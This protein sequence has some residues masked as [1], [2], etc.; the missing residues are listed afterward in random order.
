MSSTDKTVRETSEDAAP[1]E[2]SLSPGPSLNSSFDFTL[3]AP[4]TSDESLSLAPADAARLP[5]VEEGSY[6]LKAEIAQGGI[7]RILR[8][9]DQRLERPVAIKELIERTP[10][11]ERRFVREAL[12]TARLQHPNIVPV[13]EAGRWPSGEPFYAM[14]FVCG[15]ALSKVIVEAHTLDQRLA[16]LPHVIAVAE[17]MAYAHS[18]G[19]IH[20][21]LKP[22]NVLVGPFGETVVID[23]G[24]AKNL[25]DRSQTP[26]ISFN[27]SPRPEAQQVNSS[28]SGSSAL[29]L[30]GA[31]MGTPAYMPPEQA[32]GRLVDE[33]ADVYALGAML[34]HLLAGSMPYHKS[35][36]G[37][38]LKE[39]RL[40][41]PEPLDR[42]QS[43]VPKD[44]L[45]IVQKAMER[46]PDKRYK[47]AAELALDLR[48]FQTGQ[49]VQAH[50]Y[51]RRERVLRFIKRRRLPLLIL[52]AALFLVAVVATVSIMGVINARDQARHE[53]DR[54]SIAE[55]KSTDRADGLTLV[56]AKAV[57]SREPLESLAWLKT[58]SPGFDRTKTVRLI[59]A[60]AFSRGVPRLLRGPGAAVN[61]IA[62]SPDGEWLA[63]ASDD[64]RVYLWETG[65]D[66]HKVLEGHSDEVW[67]LGFHKSGGILITTSK[68][69][70]VRVWDVQQ[71]QSRALLGHEGPINGLDFLRDGRLLTAGRDGQIH[72]WNASG[73]EGKLLYNSPREELRSSVCSNAKRAVFS[74]K[75]ALFIFDA[76]NDTLQEWPG[77]ELPA[78]AIA[79]SPDGTSAVTGDDKGGLRAWDLATGKTEYFQ[80]HEASVRTLMFAHRGGRFFSGGFDRTVRVWSL[81]QNTPETIFKGHEGA[82]YRIALSPDGNSLVSASADHSARIWDLESGTARILIGAH[83]GISSAEYSK[84]GKWLAVASYDQSIRLYRVDALRDRVVG[85][86]RMAAHKMALSPDGK[87][88]ITASKDGTLLITDVETGQSRPF[89]S[90][91]GALRSLAYSS[92][93]DYVAGACE[94]GRVRLWKKSGEE[95]RIF[96]GHTRA[97]QAMDFSPGIQQ[98]KSLNTLASAGADGSVKLWTL[99]TGAVQTLYQ[100]EQGIA[101]LAFS[102]DGGKL[103]LGVEDGSVLLFSGI[104]TEIEAKERKPIRLLGHKGSVL[105]LRF[106]PDGRMLATGSLDHTIRLWSGASGACL[107]TLDAGGSG[108]EHLIFFNDGKRLASLGG[109]ANARLWNTE[110]GERMDVLRGHRARVTTMA[111]SPDGTRLA[112]GGN[113]G[114]IR[115]WELDVGESRVL[116]GHQGAVH[117]VAF[118]DGGKLLISIGEDGTIRRWMDDFP[119]E[120]A[121]VRKAIEQATPETVESMGASWL[122]PN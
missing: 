44:L 2:V 71:G 82:V 86:H 106:S 13:Y 54:A 45:T 38:V 37:D 65:G 51:S 36:S 14:K 18:E 87:H 67:E 75:G 80:G 29:T 96:E 8:A 118:G 105:S 43:G 22:Q 120:K 20:R 99:D 63:A 114:M 11:A 107:H 47:T 91:G 101:S 68:D 61:N 88:A 15:R 78:T 77:Q 26:R 108:I 9:S 117:S 100:G 33:R 115:L 73:G 59:A 41:P 10:S 116:S 112:T 4:N 110:N 7:G 60:D 90:A 31:I 62:F 52:S 111:L 27:P 76:Q 57:V 19:I 89:A 34:Y 40:G 17:A 49:I 56:E 30:S 6:G 83:D 46:E 16:L 94:D 5:V 81:G 84:D 97:V 55:Q 53:R 69:A 35:A 74:A 79:C 102:P 85:L 58:L 93:G 64:R 70:S 50:H 28:A 25:R 23:W 48:R 98:A 121:S 39:V 122:K 103:A 1:T 72:V 95:A 109:E 66:G 92:G 12:L 32:D 24:L 113:D 21:D 42:L 104:D 119:M 3:P